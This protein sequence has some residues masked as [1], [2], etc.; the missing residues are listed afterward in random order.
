MIGRNLVHASDSPA[1]GRRE[2]GIFF[3]DSE[4]LT[5]DRDLDGWIFEA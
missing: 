2:V 5:Y 4:L 1:S 3:E